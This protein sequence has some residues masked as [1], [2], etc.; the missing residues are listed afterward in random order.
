MG[1][2]LSSL[3]FFETP[4]PVKDSVSITERFA[5]VVIIHNGMNFANQKEE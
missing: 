2:S 1:N 5:S 4:S 3:C